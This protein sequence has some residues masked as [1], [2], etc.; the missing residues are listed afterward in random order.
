MQTR[1]EKSL[2][3]MNHQF[4]GFKLFSSVLE[5][6]RRNEYIENWWNLHELEKNGIPYN[7]YHIPIDILYCTDTQTQHEL[8]HASCALTPSS[9][10]ILT[11]S[12]LNILS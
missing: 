7:K 4:S 2:I 1:R 5:I 10:N 8:V 12:S 11:P 6:I 9:L 3:K